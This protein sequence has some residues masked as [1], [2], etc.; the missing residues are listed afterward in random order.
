MNGIQRLQAN[1]VDR[2]YAGGA[3]IAA[4]RRQ[5]W[6]GRNAPEDW[7]GS[8]TAVW[9]GGDADGLSRLE[10]GDTLA[11]A[12]R[13]DP[14]AFLGAAAADGAGG[15]PALLLKLLDAGQRLPVHVHPDGGFALEH[16][17]QPRGKS[18]AWVFLEAD[19]GASV[20]VGFSRDVELEELLDWT[21]RSDE[22]AMLDAMHHIPV[23]RGDTIYVPPG[24]PHSIGEGVLILE[25]QEPSDLS[26]LLEWRGLVPEADAFLGL[27][28][29]VAARAVRRSAVG[30]EELEQ[31]RSSRG[32]R[33]FPEAADEFFEAEV[34][35]R[36]VLQPPGFALLVGLEGAGVVRSAGGS[37]PVEGGTTLLVLDCAGPWHVEGDA[38]VLLCRPP[39]AAPA[40][41]LADANL[42]T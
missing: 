37:L 27:P 31:L 39:I 28:A 14:E 9:A 25:L 35:A 34:V 19:P 11:D 1:P 38:R 24:V 6:S 3:R 30:A 8:T 12:I 21:A 18:E 42:T 36:D 16:L 33:L 41:S 20:H 13:A 40:A 7:V 15:L 32:P 26:I 22:A 29:E 2:F 17:G 4:F 5:P 23:S 10:S